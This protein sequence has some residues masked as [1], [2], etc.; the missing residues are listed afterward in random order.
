ML[1]STH[2]KWATAAAMIGVLAGASSYYAGWRANVKASD[3]RDYRIEKVLN[4][5]DPLMADVRDLKGSVAVLVQ[6]Q[7]E[8]NAHLSDTNASLLSLVNVLLKDRQRQEYDR[9]MKQRGSN[10]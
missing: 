6:S 2:L 7:K 8:T 5:H 4:E 10:E 3:V 1:K 9:M